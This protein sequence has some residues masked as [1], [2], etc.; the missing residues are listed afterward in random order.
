MRR[1]HT[2]TRHTKNDTEKYE[3]Q[4]PKNDR[5]EQWAKHESNIIMVHTYG[6][7]WVWFL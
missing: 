6:R 5:I 2:H 3:N 1:A 7:F 4:K